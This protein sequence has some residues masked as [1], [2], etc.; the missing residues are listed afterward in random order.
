[1]CRKKTR[2]LPIILQTSINV[3]LGSWTEKTERLSWS[4]A[5]NFWSRE[6][7]KCL[8]TQF[9]Y[10]CG[11]KYWFLWD[12]LLLNIICVLGRI[13]LS[14]NIVCFIEYRMYGS[15]RK[16]LSQRNMVHLWTIH[17][18]FLTSWTSPDFPKLYIRNFR[19]RPKFYYYYFHYSLVLLFRA[20]SL[21]VDPV[22]SAWPSHV[23]SLCLEPL[24]YS[25][26]R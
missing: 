9:Y 15:L 16:N 26:Q 10:F 5:I 4:E 8:G 6:C 11:P 7:I 3:T 14:I 17:D 22:L 24:N 13:L 2:R 1:M 25:W 21:P 18:K 23:P 20:G 12:L 19:V